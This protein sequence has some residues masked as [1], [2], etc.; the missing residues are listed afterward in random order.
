MR[1]C[2]T[3]KTARELAAKMRKKGYKATVYNSK[4]KGVRVYVKRK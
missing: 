2:H 3:M 1:N 4:G